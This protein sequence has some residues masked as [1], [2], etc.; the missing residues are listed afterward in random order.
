[1]GPPPVPPRA[2]KT[3]QETGRQL[4]PHLTQNNAFRREPRPVNPEP[5]TPASS[6]APSLPSHSPLATHA[7]LS[8]VS[9]LIGSVAGLPLPQGTDLE[10]VRKD[11]MHTAAARA[12]QRREQEEAER[13]AQKG[14]ARKKAQELE[15]KM[16]AAALE[17]EKQ[18]EQKKE[19]AEAEAKQ[20]APPSPAPSKV[21]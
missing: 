11:V 8:T 19:A 13:E 14:R 12:K 2:L 1:M 21:S 10:E 20:A 18:E 7:Q 9:P 6:K 3:A 4:P 16:R 17:K 5:P 15:E